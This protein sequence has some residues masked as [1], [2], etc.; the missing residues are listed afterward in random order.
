MDCHVSLGELHMQYCK[1]K[2]MEKTI[3]FCEVCEDTN[4]EESA[5]GSIPQPVPDCNELPNFHYLGVDKHLQC[6]K[7]NQCTVWMIFI[8]GY[9]H[10][11]GQLRLSDGDSIKS[12]SLK[13][14]VS[15][16]L[17][18]K[19]VSHLSE[20]K[21]SRE[22]RKQEHKSNNAKEDKMEYTDFNWKH[23]FETGKLKKKRKTVRE[24]YIK[25]SQI[26]CTRK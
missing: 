8:P 23:L 5:G 7:M 19:Y 22:R 11:S 21:T 10:E 2:C 13:Y 24:K 17:V 12:F 20:I 1:G 4:L 16:S 25:T 6:I 15:E 3:N 18:K 26:D 9:N 14:I